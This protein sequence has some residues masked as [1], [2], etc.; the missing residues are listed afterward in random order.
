MKKTKFVSGLLSAVLVLS[1]FAVPA[2]AADVTQTNSGGTATVSYTNDS[3]WTATIPTYVAPVEDGQQDV[4]AY[5]VAVKDVVIGD[6]QQLAATVEYSGYVTEAN[7]VKIP[8]QLYDSN[9]EE[10]QS[11]DTILSKSAG[12][13]NT[14]AA[15]TFGAALTASPK[16]AGVYTDTATFAFTAKDKAYTL[17]EI[18]ADE[19]LSAIGKTK[20]EYVVARFNDDYSEVTIFANGEDSNGIM[21]DFFSA[22]LIPS[23]IAKHKETLLS[24]NIIEGVTTIGQ[25]AFDQ[26]EA[27]INVTFPN[28]LTEISDAAFAECRA[29]SGTLVIPS[30]VQRLG[31]CAFQ[32][33]GFEHIDI[34]AKLTTIERDTFYGC[35]SLKSVKLPETLTEINDGAFSHCGSLSSI[36][37]PESVTSLG[38][39]AFAYNGLASITGGEGLEVIGD[40]CFQWSTK[41]ISF[42][43]PEGLKEIGANAFYTPANPGYDGGLNYVTIPSTVEKIGDGAFSCLT[44]KGFSVAS[45]N[46]YFVA[47][48]NV[49]YTADGTRLIRCATENSPTT[50]IGSAS[51]TDIDP[52]ALRNCSLFTDIDF[53]KTKL[54]NIKEYTFAGCTTAKQISL[55]N[56]VVKIE[57]L[58]FD[59]CTSLREFNFPNQLSEIGYAAFSGC[60][61][62]HVS[63]SETV[64][65]VG[66]LA[67]AH[68]SSL[69]SI[70]ILNPTLNINSWFA[71]D[72]PNLTTIYGK[73][74]STAETWAA[75]N[76][77]TFIAQ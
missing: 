72:C 60:G 6:N 32:Y 34:R 59:S 37:I 12:E 10:I 71:E 57:Q 22:S 66:S 31:S 68:N 47:V 24:A 76:G 7:G 56:T 21:K 14:E 41:Q 70:S 73:S 19:H 18:N 16:Y 17:D 43:F 27:L 11:G 65:S 15:I 51:L 49:L 1:A 67:F 39:N 74:G 63:L 52:Y 26:C 55:P 48:D 25:Y 54:T 33:T 58:A 8:Y 44:I 30:S 42:V 29:L 28:T 38:S 9:G 75:E 13:P 35:F 36:D 4:S 2:A 20:P 69:T 77:Y 61:L 23:P 64:S 45:G 50:L 46:K 62:S 40:E 5:E 53:S 3:M